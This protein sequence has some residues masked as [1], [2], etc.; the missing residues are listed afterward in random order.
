[1]AGGVA[2]PFETEVGGEGVMDEDALEVLADIAVSDADAQ[3]RERL[4]A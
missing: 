3:R 1:M 2:H 4:C